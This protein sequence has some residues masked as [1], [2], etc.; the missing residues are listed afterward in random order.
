MRP[1]FRNRVQAMGIDEIVTE[2]LSPRQNLG[3]VVQFPPCS[4]VLTSKARKWISSGLMPTK[5]FV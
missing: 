5:F 3:S 2:P 4:A 1:A